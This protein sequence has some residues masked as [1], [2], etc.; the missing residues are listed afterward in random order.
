[1]HLE[2]LGL[3][4]FRSYPALDLALEPGGTVFLG[5]NGQGKT[6][7]IE[8]VAFLAT[9]HSH[10]VASDAPLVRSGAER[11]V[12]R[13]SVVHSGR[14]ILVELEVNP[15]RTNRARVAGAP[16]PRAREALGVVRTV[17]V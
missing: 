6:N 4:D 16:V 17:L 9:H 13:A 3:V 1:M 8:A 5:P 11:A 7:L 12:V 14:S 15:G 2:R 10:R